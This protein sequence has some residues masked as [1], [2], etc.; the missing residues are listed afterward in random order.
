MGIKVIFIQLPCLTF[1][2]RPQ[3]KH[4]PF[5][6]LLEQLSTDLTARACDISL[7]W[8]PRSITGFIAL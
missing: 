7:A 3:K 1:R 6:S 8:Q 5:H 4:T 2:S